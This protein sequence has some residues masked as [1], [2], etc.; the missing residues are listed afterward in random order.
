M[1]SPIF[2]DDFFKKLYLNA[3]EG[4][5][6]VSFSKDWLYVTK[7]VGVSSIVRIDIC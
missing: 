6:G 4:L 5:P 7:S 1:Y 2:L 3:E